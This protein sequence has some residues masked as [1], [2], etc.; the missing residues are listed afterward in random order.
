MQLANQENIAVSCG[1][2][3]CT[4]FPSVLADFLDL[5][6]HTA[7]TMLTSFP[8]AVKSQKRGDTFRLFLRGSSRSISSVARGMLGG[9]HR[10]MG[11]ARLTSSTPCAFHCLAV[12]STATR[13]MR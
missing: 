11:E 6:T 8:N 10:M 9:P 12:C 4:I 7:V 1:V 13:L 2:L 5:L 3:Q